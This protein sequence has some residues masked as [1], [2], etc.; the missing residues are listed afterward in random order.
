MKL[1]VRWFVMGVLTFL[2][3]GELLLRSVPVPTAT[4]TGYYV[5]PNILTYPPMHTWTV[6]TGWD[7]RNPQRLKSNNFGFVAGRQFSRDESAIALIGD[8]YVE[9]SMLEADARPG[10][11]LERALDGRRPVYAMGAPGSALLDYAER[12]RFAHE[13][14]AVRDFVL[15]LETGDPLQSLCGSGN[16][17]ATCLDRRTLEPRIERMET[18]STLKLVLRDSALAQYFAGTLRASPKRLWNSAIAQSRG[19]A[20]AQLKSVPVRPVSSSDPAQMQAVDAVT[21]YFFERVK[22]HVQ[23]RL[24][25]VVTSDLEVLRQGELPINHSRTRFI[26]LARQLGAEV[27]DADPIFMAHFGKSRLRLDVGPYD[28]HLNSLGVQLLMGAV[29]DVMRT[30]G[31]PK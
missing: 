28:G 30:N 14:L 7:L 23:G 8:S 18:P 19:A 26:Q 25:L 13:R 20:S 5:D 9:A 24:V 2:V 22:P 3:A 15:L 29:A 4:R 27:I 10:A 17:H 12:V 11:Q 16:N 21:R 1:S 31:L 6:S